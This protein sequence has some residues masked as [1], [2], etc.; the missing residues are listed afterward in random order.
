MQSIDGTAI[1]DLPL[2]RSVDIDV[3]VIA[4]NSLSGRLS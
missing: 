1:R 4:S 3:L 2:M